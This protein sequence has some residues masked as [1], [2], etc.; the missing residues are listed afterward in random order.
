MSYSS[1]LRQGRKSTGFSQTVERVCA[2]KKKKILAWT[3]FSS[4]RKKRRVSR[5]PSIVG[6]SRACAT[7]GR[8]D[9]S[10]IN[11]KTA[12]RRGK[13]FYRGGAGSRANIFVASRCGALTLG[14]G[15]ENIGGNLASGR[16]SARY[17]RRE[18][19]SSKL[20]LRGPA[21]PSTTAKLILKYCRPIGPGG[22]FSTSLPKRG[23]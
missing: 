20:A 22:H 21:R 5:A 15:R 2:I 6:S 18:R 19:F 4:S 14:R 8:I 9:R 17:A 3:T 7:L 23:R 12:E 10:A 13:A 1:T 16:S 11:S